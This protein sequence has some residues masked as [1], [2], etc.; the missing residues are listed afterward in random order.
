MKT[1]PRPLQTGPRE[2]ALVLEERDE[3]RCIRDLVAATILDAL[4]RKR[5]EQDH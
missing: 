4:E 5:V 2:E 3:V 1:A